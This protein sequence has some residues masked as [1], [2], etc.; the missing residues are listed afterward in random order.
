MTDMDVVTDYQTK[1]D[2]YWKSADRTGESGRDLNRIAEQIVMTCGVGRTLDIG[3]GEGLLV[4]KLLRQ[5]VDAHGVDVSEVVVSRCNRRLPSRFTHASVLALP[6]ED[7][8]FKTAVSTDCMEHLVPADIPQA[9]KEFHRVTERFV[10]LQ[11]ATTP[12]RDGHWHLTIENRAWWEARCF[13]AGFRKHPLYYRINSYESLN[14]DDWQIYVLLEKVPSEA[15]KWFDLNS[16]VE[17]SCYIATCCVKLAGVAMHTAFVITKPPRTYV[18]EIASWTSRAA[19]D[20]A[21]IFC[22]RPP[23]QRQL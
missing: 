16:L 17:E 9:L 2:G 14:K 7:G 3:S 10:F 11:I 19:W 23:K 5:G 8:S 1:Y 18:R 12:D 20:M 4:A 21:H 13:E 22:I 6:F 15:L